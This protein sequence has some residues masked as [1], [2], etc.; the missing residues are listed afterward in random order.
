M[1]TS[2]PVYNIAGDQDPVGQYGEGI[3]AVSNWLAE[4]GH[5]IK[6]QKFTRDIGMRYIII[7]ILGMKLRME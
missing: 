7:G 4:T 6:K 2:I 3:Y 1:P 5:K